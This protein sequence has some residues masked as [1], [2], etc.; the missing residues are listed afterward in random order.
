MEMKQAEHQQ[1]GLPMKAA[2]STARRQLGNIT[3]LKEQ[4]RQ[5]WIWGWLEKQRRKIRGMPFV[6]FEEAPVLR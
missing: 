1:R 6:C 5:M 4:S 2:Q 3:L